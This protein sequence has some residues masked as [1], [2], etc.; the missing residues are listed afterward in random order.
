MDWEIQYDQKVEWD[1]QGLRKRGKWGNYSL[2][3]N[4]RL[5]EPK[6]VKL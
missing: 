3:T 4:I 5:A 6:T 2:E 1:C